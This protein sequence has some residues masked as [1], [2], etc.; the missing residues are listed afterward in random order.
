MATLDKSKPF[1]EVYGPAPYRFEQNGKYFSAQGF[2]VD[3]KGTPVDTPDP[4]PIGQHDQDGDGNLTVPEIKAALDELG[5][6]YGKTEKRDSLLDK[7]KEA[8]Q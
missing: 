6:E 8:T 2:E 7:L 1:G 4:E 5:I 3:E